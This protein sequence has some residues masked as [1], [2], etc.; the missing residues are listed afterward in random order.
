MR[1]ALWFLWVC[2]GWGAVQAAAAE[3]DAA[4]PPTRPRV[5]LVLS[6]GGARGAAH[7]GVLKVLDELHVPV[8]VIVGT[9]MGAVVGGLYA[10]GLNGVQ[11]EAALTG[12]DWQDA[13]RDRPARR[14]LSF[15]RK[16]EDQDFLVQLPLGLKKGFFVLPRGLIQGQKLGRLLRELTRPVALVQDFDRL[17][18]P[19]RAVATDLESGQAVVMN[20]GD[21]ATAIRASL[22]APGLF[23]PVE[24][25]GRLLVD[26]GLTENLPIEVARALHVDVLIVVDVTFPLADRESLDSVTRISNQMLA[27]LVRKDSLRQRALLTGR[28]VQIA[29][30]LG[31]SSTFDFSRLQSSM[32]LGEQAA[33]SALTQL[34]ALALSPQDYQQYLQ[35]RTDR[36]STAVPQIDFVRSE[37]G[38]EARAAAV[39]AFFGDLA[40]QPL[41]PP[42]LSSRINEFYG[43]GTLESLDYQLLLNSSGDQTG[44]VFKLRPNSWGPDY[45]R[46]GLGLQDDFSGNSS[47]DATARLVMT[48]LN[49]NGAEWQSELRVGTN[50]RLTTELFL[51]LSA[52]QQYFFAPHARFEVKNLPQIVAEEPVGALRVRSLGYG[53]DAGRQFGN[54]SE[55]RVGVERE[56]GSTRVRLGRIDQARTEFSTR[57]YFTRFTYDTIDKAAFPGKGDVLSLEWR[58]EMQDAAPDAPSDSLRLDWRMARSEGRNTLVWWTSAGSYRVPQRTAPRSYFSLGGFLNLSGLTP[59]ALSAPHYAISRLIFYRKVGFGGEGFLNV[60]LYLGASLEAGNAW[61][62]RSQMRLS[63][64]RKDASVFFGADTFL[65]PAYIAAGYDDRGRSAFYLFLGRGF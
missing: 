54:T 32:A 23:A 44:L 46:F 25:D 56:K 6:G 1:I 65:G 63:S 12:V 28:D 58:G 39:D 51:P 60:P 13:F 11:I 15:R 22:S 19:F 21:L 57:E 20:D 34:S 55:L 5:G 52:R 50:P 16:R 62:D 24:R 47:F 53:L 31:D 27:I 17:P 4:A 64:A 59:D 26:G 3:S 36:S 30:A 8:D 43:Q 42:L 10:S 2:C 40:G 29:P 9:S 49:R 41:N 35:A 33:R 18:V 61:M 7:V 38:A 45:V 14:E 37:R 48:E